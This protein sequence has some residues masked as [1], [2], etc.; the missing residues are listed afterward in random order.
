MN[1]KQPPITMEDQIAFL[2]TYANMLKAQQEMVL[3]QIKFL[4]AGKDI[5]DNLMQFQNLFNVGS[6]FNNTENKK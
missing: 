6:F 5:Q 2:E 3:M 4:K 1:T